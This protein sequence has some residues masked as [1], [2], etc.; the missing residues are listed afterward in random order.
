MER[1]FGPEK[2]VATCGDLD[3]EQEGQTIGLR[4]RERAEYVPFVKFTV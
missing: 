1:A 2:G 4:R 3:R